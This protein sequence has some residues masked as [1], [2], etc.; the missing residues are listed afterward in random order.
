MDVFDLYAKINLDT[1]DYEKQL[2]DAEQKTSGFGS[3]LGSGL[4]KVARVGATAIA[5]V[6]AAVAGVSA[7]FIKGASDIAAY[8]D[9]IDK[10]SQKMGLSA[11][12]YQEWDA[13]MQHSGTSIDAMSRG[14]QTLQKNAVNSAEKFE[15]LGIS[16]KQLASMSTE[17]LFAATIEGLQNMEAGAERTALANELLGGSAKELGALLNTSA[18]ET[19]AMRDRVHEL[20]GVMSDEAIK[21]AAKYQDTLQDMKT[22]FSGLQRGMQ[23][24]FLPA[25]TTVMEGLTEV[26][27]GGDGFDKI[28]Q[29]INEFTAKI[30]DALP[31]VIEVGGK[32]IASLARAI[33]DNI[34]KIAASALDVVSTFG[35]AILKGLPKVLSDASDLLPDIFGGI[36]DY[37]AQALEKIVDAVPPLI[38]SISK[39]LQNFIKSLPKIMQGIKKI[40]PQLIRLVTDLVE[41]VVAQ[42]PD[43]LTALFDAL[44]DILEMIFETL[45]DNANLIINSLMRLFNIIVRTLPRLIS[46]IVQALPRL[47]SMIVQVLPKLITMIVNALVQNMPIIINGIVTLITEIVKQLPALLMAFIDAIIDFGPELLKAFGK[48]LGSI[49]TVIPKIAGQLWEAAKELGKSIID[50]IIA[51]FEDPIGNLE[52]AGDWILSQIFGENVTVAEVADAFTKWWNTEGLGALSNENWSDI[53][54]GVSLMLDDAGA[55]FLNEFF[56]TEIN[57]QEFGEYFTKWW[58]TDGLGA[59]TSADWEDIM[60]GLSLMLKDNPT[61]FSDMLL[62]TMGAI[63]IGPLTDQIADDIL[64]IQEP[65]NELQGRLNEMGIGWNEFWGGVAGTWGLENAVTGIGGVTTQFNIGKWLDGSIFQ[66]IKDDFD[67][68]KEWWDAGW[69]AAFSVIIEKFEEYQNPI[70]AIW[71][72]IKSSFPVN[73]AYDW[74]VELVESFF[75]GIMNT[76]AGYTGSSIAGLQVGRDIAN[77]VTTEDGNSR[78]IEGPNAPNDVVTGPISP[79]GYGRGT[80]SVNPYDLSIYNNA[81]DTYNA[82]KFSAPEATMSAGAAYSYTERNMASM[83]RMIELLENIADKDMGVSLE[84]DAAGI[85]RVVEKE[86]KLRTR[87]SGYNRLAMTGV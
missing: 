85:F 3:S 69:G 31:D 36:G 22:A 33:A 15:A 24:E 57:A 23:A 67:A 25:I 27:S 54:S 80:E 79:S 53:L 61:W 47:I 32:I 11:E 81:L 35:S 44:P 30:T 46:M 82:N 68:F 26:F 84:G 1:S 48:A 12:A 58:N 5:G 9:N 20:G 78:R 72:L 21:A 10:M 14:M 7:V 56:G 83:D 6:S 55:F 4:S 42:L 76:L 29:G 43:I 70:A 64:A 18:E 87:A 63:D 8:G 17:E 71:E 62:G 37:I 39:V 41:S 13:I 28:S 60:G 86:N 51:F 66:P 75:N 34:P 65:M 50:G 49:I 74:G 45:L 16:Q 19:K 2:N 73:E 59:I 38:S 77:K 52:I 40:L